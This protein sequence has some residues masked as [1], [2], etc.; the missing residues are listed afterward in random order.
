M[1]KPGLNHTTNFVLTLID[2]LQGLGYDLYTDRFYTSPILAHELLH[3]DTTLTGT[4]MC[5]HKNMPMASK[6]MKQ[7]K[8][9]V[10]M[11]C[12]GKMVVVQWTDKRTLIALRTKHTNAMADSS[13]VSGTKTTL[14]VF[15]HKLYIQYNDTYR[16][17]KYII[18]MTPIDILVHNRS[19]NQWLSTNTTNTFILSHQTFQYTVKLGKGRTTGFL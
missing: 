6:S 12:K 19:P 7:K 17:I 14:R 16:H 9:N 2:P 4:V 10:D 15:Q 5:N 13:Q 8:G 18:C 11:Y 1:T 3:V